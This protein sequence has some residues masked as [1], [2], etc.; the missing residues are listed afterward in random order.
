MEG[1]NRD[2]KSIRETTGAPTGARLGFGIIMII[3]YVGVGLLFIFNVF[4]IIN[5]TVSIIIGVLLII[6]GIWR[7]YRLYKGMN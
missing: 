2:R 1:Y 4:D 3:V 5:L 7:A 6:Y